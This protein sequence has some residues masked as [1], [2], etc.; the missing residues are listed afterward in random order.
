MYMVM[1][2]YPHALETICGLSRTEVLL[3]SKCSNRMPVRRLSRTIPVSAIRASLPINY[4]NVHGD[5]S[6]NK[7]ALTL[8]ETPAT[9]AE[10]SSHACHSIY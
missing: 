5:I 7:V 3:L 9:S 8:A 6:N 2:P 4:A 10:T 1:R